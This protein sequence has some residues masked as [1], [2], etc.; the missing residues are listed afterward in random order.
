MHEIC[1]DTSAYLLP[2]DNVPNNGKHQKQLIDQRAI[3]RIKELANE[4]I[5]KLFI[6]A[7]VH[8][9]CRQHHDREKRSKA[10]EFW[11]AVKPELIPQEIGF[12]G[13]QAAIGRDQEYKT[14]LNQHEAELA[15]LRD[16]S[17]DSSII[18]NSSFF[19]KT[20]VTSD[21]KR[22]KK[23]KRQL[24]SK[25]RVLRPSEFLASISQ[26]ITKP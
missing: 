8:I 5:V 20:I 9:E 24:G 1:L 14:A 7:N 19:G 10:D 21:Y 18:L 3:F 23:I 11:K 17:L 12:H 22:I 4:G 2:C 13:I 15:K 16:R 25:V 6:P 26:D